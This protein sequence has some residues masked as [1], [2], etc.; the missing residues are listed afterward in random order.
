[1]KLP[2][3]FCARLRVFLQLGKAICTKGVLNIMFDS[4]SFLP[5]ADDANPNPIPAIS[6]HWHPVG[7]RGEGLP[8]TPGVYRFRVPMESRPEETVEFLAQLR[9]RK[10][11]VHQVLMPTFEYVLDDEFITLP[12]GTYWRER[13]PGDPETLGVTQFP[14]AP[15]MAHGATECPF[16]HQQPVINGEKIKEDDGDRYYT[17]IPYKFNRF[18]FSCCEWISKAPRPSISALKHDWSQR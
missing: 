3:P 18:W 10:H 13:V 2:S 12:E 11:G 17:H 8:T 1:M 9:W 16:C 6:D 14:I 5:M 7:T 15:E 4:H